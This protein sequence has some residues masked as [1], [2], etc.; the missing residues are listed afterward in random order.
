[1]GFQ[2][3][4]PASFPDCEVSVVAVVVALCVCAVPMPTPTMPSTS[5]NNIASRAPL[6]AI[7]HDWNPDVILAYGHEP[8]PQSLLE[9]RSAEVTGRGVEMPVQR[10]VSVARK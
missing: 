6:R 3:P 4:S 10:A 7:H 8:V 1:M 9:N 2:G 5:S